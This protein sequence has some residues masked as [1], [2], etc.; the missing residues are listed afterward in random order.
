MQRQLGASAVTFKSVITEAA[1]L[2]SSATLLINC[3]TAVVVYKNVCVKLSV[4]FL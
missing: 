3:G 4:F 1:Q 2:Y